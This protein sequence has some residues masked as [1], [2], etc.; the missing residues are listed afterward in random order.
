MKVFSYWKY[1]LGLILGGLI[2]VLVLVLDALPKLFR[3]D[4]IETKELIIYFTSCAIGFG[5]FIG[6]ALQNRTSR[7][8]T[9]EKELK[10]YRK[11]FNQES[12]IQDDHNF[13]AEQRLQHKKHW[14][15]KMGI[16]FHYEDE[17]TPEEKES[18]LERTRTIEKIKRN[19]EE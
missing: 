4:L 15:K 3:Y 11:M 6:L 10:D 9:K 7:K 5:F 8:A 2:G 18:I 12:I 13:N 16:I 19:L 14:Y 17:L 1:I